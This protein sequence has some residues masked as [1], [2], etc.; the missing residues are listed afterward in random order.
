[1]AVVVRYRYGVGPV[2]ALTAARD[3]L[4]SPGGRVYLAQAGSYSAAVASLIA[5][6]DARHRAAHALN[7]SRMQAGLSPLPPDAALV[8]ASPGPG[9]ML[10]GD[11]VQLCRE[12]SGDPL[13]KWGYSSEP[14]PEI[15]ARVWGG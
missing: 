8:A 11:S 5:E 4:N 14:S 13:W 12:L 1:M 9:V 2:S 10:T 7:T 15:P 3:W 6:D